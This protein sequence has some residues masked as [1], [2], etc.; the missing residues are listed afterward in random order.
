MVS[1]ESSGPANLTRRGVLGLG[2]GLGGAI[3]LSACSV[4]VSGD[5]A[6]VTP[7]GITFPANKAK[8]PTGEVSFRWVDSGASKV[9]FNKAVVEAY[10][11]QHPN[12]TLNYTGQGWP[13]V[14]ETVTL[15]IRNGSAPD[16]FALPQAVPPATAI[17]EGWVR[18]LEDIIPDFE[19]WRKAWPEGSFVPGE[20]V[21]N[22]KLYTLPLNGNRRLSQMVVYDV[23]TF[24]DAG[25]DPAR[26]LGSW[27]EMRAAARK[28]TEK[29]AGKT[30]G[31]IVPGGQRIGRVVMELA[32][33]AGW[34]SSETMGGM[35]YKT[36]EYAVDAPE[37]L[38]GLEQL[39]AFVTDKSMFPGYL[40][41][42]NQDVTGRMPNRVAA[43]TFDGP[44]NIE[45]WRVSNPEWEF[46]LVKQPP[47][48]KGKRYTEP[49]ENVGVNNLWVYAKSPHPEIAGD[50]LA[51][52]GSVDGQ[53]ELI[54]LSRGTLVSVFPQAMEMAKKFD[55]DPMAKEADRLAQEIM[56]ASPIV[57]I[58]NVDADKVAL[59]LKPVKPDIND[60][61]QG[62]FTGK[63]TDARKALTELNSGLN[64]ALDDAIAAARAKG[65][66]ISREDWVFPNWDPSKDYTPQQYKEL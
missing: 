66:K 14:N 53:A 59:A 11:A 41:M 19:Q 21:F 15:G 31:L 40:T 51:Y 3:A 30:Y 42:K 27:D 56:R 5:A 28:I 34:R 1:T 17:A 38:Q 33:S 20:H 6:A 50:I 2:L 12:V 7:K 43:M 32:V 22:G 39:Q 13:V 52:M 58:R 8:L 63:I 55:L 61:V 29:G 60:I 18:P 10:H 44:W 45:G 4:K 24:S 46:G 48:E 35:D 26:D 16:L 9:P 64:K 23:K 36:G 57:S 37:M 62:I 25:I 65:A 54:R 49:F 47:R